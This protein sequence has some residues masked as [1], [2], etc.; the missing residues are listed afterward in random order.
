MVKIRSS[1]DMSEDRAVG[2]SYATT[3]S[4]VAGNSN[5]QW[6]CTADV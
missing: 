3:I 4:G 5:S 6:H 1:H 2:L